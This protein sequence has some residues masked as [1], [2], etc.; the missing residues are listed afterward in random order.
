MVVSAYSLMEL[1]DAKNRLSVLSKLWKK[2]NKYLVI[3]EQGTNAGFKVGFII[4]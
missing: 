2:T 1:P 3:V 4:C